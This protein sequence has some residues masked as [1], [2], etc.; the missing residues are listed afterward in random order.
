VVSLG[1]GAF[2]IEY[3][4]NRVYCEACPYRDTLPKALL[5]KGL[6]FKEC[7]WTVE[8]IDS[9]DKSKPTPY[10]LTKLKGKSYRVSIQLTGLE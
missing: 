5:I 4:H 10:E 6:F 3:M 8:E 7:L 1:T 2:S 9:Y